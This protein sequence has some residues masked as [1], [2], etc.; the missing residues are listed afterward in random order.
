M[1]S[2]ILAGALVAIGFLDPELFHR[3]FIFVLS[4]LLYTLIISVPT[5]WA[6]NKFVQP[7]GFDGNDSDEPWKPWQTT[8][9]VLALIAIFTASTLIAV[10]LAR[11]VRTGSPEIYDD[12][13]RTY[14]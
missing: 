10:S 3:I 13:E 9:L 11:D 4:F 14:P 2:G 8:L 5:L 12:V 1:A 6:F 7:L